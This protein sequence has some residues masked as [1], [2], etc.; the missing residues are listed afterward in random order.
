MSVADW[1]YPD[2][3]NYLANLWLKAHVQ[4]AVS[5]VQHQ[6]GAAPQV[7]FPTLQ[8]VNKTTR[9]G[10]TYLHTYSQTEKT[11]IIRCFVWAAQLLDT[12]ILNYT[13]LWIIYCM[14]S[15]TTVPTPLEVSKL[16]SFR[17]SAI[18][19]GAFDTGRPAI[20]ICNLLNLL[21]QLSGWRQHQTLWREVKVQCFTGGLYTLDK[22]LS[23][24]KCNLHSLLGHLLSLGKAGGWYVQLKEGDTAGKEK[25]TKHKQHLN[26]YI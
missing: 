19:T 5:L 11:Y 3:F 20:R 14:W 26:I 22:T 7:S 6:V 1:A 10:D 23:L 16:W 8:E 25:Q 21:S 2:L 17:C 24:H 9:C 13:L 18:D 4:H 15:S 12:H